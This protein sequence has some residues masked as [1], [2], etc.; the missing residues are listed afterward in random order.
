MFR[1]SPEE[2]KVCILVLV[3]QLEMLWTLFLKSFFFFFFFFFVFLLGWSLLFSFSRFFVMAMPRI[4]NRGLGQYKYRKTKKPRRSMC[5]IESRPYHFLLPVHVLAITKVKH[6][7]MVLTGKLKKI[8]WKSMVG[9]CI[10]Y[11]NSPSLG[12]HLSF[13]GVCNK[14]NPAGDSVSVLK[15]SCTWLLH[16][17]FTPRMQRG[18]LESGGWWC[19]RFGGMLVGVLWSFVEGFIQASLVRS[20]WYQC[21]E[22]VVLGLFVKSLPGPQILEDKNRVLWFG[23]LYLVTSKYWMLLIKNLGLLLST[24]F[25]FFFF[26]SRICNK[27]TVLHLEV[28]G[29]LVAWHRSPISGKHHR[30]LGASAVVSCIQP[31]TYCL[32]QVRGPFLWL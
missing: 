10:S 28:A 20:T 29:V 12:G 30:R 3:G 16:G 31:T 4:R 26:Q 13:R 1:K 15:A 17:A 23:I 2:C 19:L 27:K 7:M 22:W 9:R 24:T 18:R 5:M 6:E 14:E 21:F 11:W 32:L 25:L 8:P